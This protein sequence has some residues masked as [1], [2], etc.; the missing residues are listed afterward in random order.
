MRRV[1]IRANDI[2]QELFDLRHARAAPGD[3]DPLK[4]HTASLSKRLLAE[5]LPLTPAA[6]EATVM[7]RLCEEEARLQE[8]VQGRR[9]YLEGIS[10]DVTDGFPDDVNVHMQQ[11]SADV[12]DAILAR[13]LVDTAS[14]IQGLV[15]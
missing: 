8:V 9:H 7:A 5:T 12:A 14:Y 15:Q 4:P 2:L 1:L 10:V 6:I 13:C 11:L 3:T